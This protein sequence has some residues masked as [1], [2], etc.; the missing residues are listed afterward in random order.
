MKVSRGLHLTDSYCK[1]THPEGCLI[2][3]YVDKN[4]LVYIYSHRIPTNLRFLL[5][6]IG[7]Q[8]GGEEE[9]NQVF[10]KYFTT[11]IASDKRILLESLS[12]TRN[13]RM[14]QR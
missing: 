5:Y 4:E 3:T 6:S 2:K 9:W 12:Y 13:P 11:H 14:I 10:N 8:E 1:N 7:V